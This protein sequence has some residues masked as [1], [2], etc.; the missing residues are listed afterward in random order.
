MLK[1]LA[2]FLLA[3][4][5]IGMIVFGN[6][7]F[8]FNFTKTELEQAYKSDNLKTMRQA[9]R[10]QAQAI[11]DDGALN[12]DIK[13]NKTTLSKQREEFYASKVMQKISHF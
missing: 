12:C 6:W 2:Q 7:A 10:Y 1:I 9:N 13:Y 5:L 3:L 4:F 11:N 8:I